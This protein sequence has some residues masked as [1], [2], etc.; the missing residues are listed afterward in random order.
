MELQQITAL[1]LLLTVSVLSTTRWIH[2]A[3]V[4]LAGALLAVVLAGWSGVA[5]TP[6]SEVLLVTAGLMVLAGYLK[7]TGLASWLALKAAKVAGGR[8]SR[9]LL[10]TGVVTFVLGAL[11]GPVAAV[12]LV[13]PVALL[14]AVEL[15]VPPLPFVAVLSWTSILGAATT[16]TAL[17]G[18]VWLGSVLHLE[19]VPWL[20]TMAP[21]TVTALVATL[22][23]GFLFF[24]KRLRV[25][26]E[27]R[28]RVLEYE[29]ARSL[30]EG[31]LLWKTVAVAALV[32]VG[33]VV[34]PWA[35]LSPSLVTVAGAVLLWLGD[36]PK[37]ADR[38]LGE[39]EGATLLFFGG[40]MAV[41][42]VFSAS[43]LVETWALAAPHPLVSL[44]L[45]A[46][47]GAFL[48]QGTAVGLLVPF[49]TTWTSSPAL[50]TTVVLGTTLGA[51]VSILGSVAGATALG[52]TG[53]GSRKVGWKEFSL[54][55]LLFGGV[56]LVVVALLIVFLG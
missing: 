19:W 10:L 47:L 55:G 52:L 14:L 22:A 29:A 54:S 38:F 13:V 48:D 12:A 36:S 50:W 26:N 25:T 2:R 1:L 27:R 4:A 31:A 35:G 16:L 53:Q 46:V 7:R 30:A 18:N 24:G 51:G 45:S 6:I 20:Q 8:P 37:A 43:G 5:A 44:G 34:G 3:A 21:Y 49:L 32:V 17:P 33:L 40:L 42:G 56:N 23:T 9:I 28:A 39:V 15:D 41:V 11:V